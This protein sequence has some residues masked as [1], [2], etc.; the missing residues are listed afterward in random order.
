MCLFS[1][2]N[3]EKDTLIMINL[4]TDVGKYD[5]HS[6]VTESKYVLQ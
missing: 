2:I 6:E 1:D 3:K 4:K 5:G